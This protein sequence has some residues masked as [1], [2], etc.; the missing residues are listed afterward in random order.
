MADKKDH[1]ERP[2]LPWRI[3]MSNAILTECGLNAAEVKT[4]TRDQ[5]KAGMIQHGQRRM[6]LLTCMT[7]LDTARRWGT[8]EDDP[9][10]VMLREIHWEGRGKDTTLRKELR[11]IVTLIDRHRDEFVALATSDAEMWAELKTLDGDKP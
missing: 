6:Y 5:F 7:C 9:R 3:Y 1:I 8:W 4:L 2:L 11:A 10:Q